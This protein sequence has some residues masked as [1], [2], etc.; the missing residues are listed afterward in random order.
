MFFTFSPGLVPG[1]N[2]LHIALA[3]GDGALLTG[4]HL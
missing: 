1:V 4:S 2:I 3:I